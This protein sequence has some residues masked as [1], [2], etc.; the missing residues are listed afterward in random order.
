MKGYFIIAM[1][2]LQVRSTNYS[3]ALWL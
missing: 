1:Y 2:G 3:E